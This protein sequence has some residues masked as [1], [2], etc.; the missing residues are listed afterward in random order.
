VKFIGVYPYH[1]S[2]QRFKV[3]PARYV[4]K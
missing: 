3:H 1:G 2:L 4:H